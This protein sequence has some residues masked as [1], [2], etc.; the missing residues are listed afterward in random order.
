MGD[1]LEKASGLVEELEVFGAAF[2]R[3]GFNAVGAERE[4]ILRDAIEQPAP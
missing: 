3:A 2:S 4:A 1:F